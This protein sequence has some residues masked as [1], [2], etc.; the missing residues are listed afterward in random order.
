MDVDQTEPLYRYPYP[1]PELADQHPF[2]AHEHQ[3]LEDGEMSR[4]AKAFLA[5][6]AKRR[7]V[8]MFS[9]DPVPRDLIEVAVAAASTAP[10]GAHKQP[11]TFV[12]ISDPRT[13]ARICEAA[14]AEE[15]TNYLQNRMNAEWQ[16]SLA[17]LGTDHHKE[18]LEV[19]PWLVVLFEQR[20]ELRTDGSTRKNYYVKE[21]VGIAAG[22]FL[23]AIHDMGLAALPHTPSP[24]AFLRTLLGRPENERPFAMFPVGHPLPGVRVPDLQ[25]KAL[26]EVLIVLERSD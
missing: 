13:K 4:R 25:R 23:T 19:A 9:S 21:S 7:S 18:F 24:M 22:L 14:E 12:A 8:R 3:R 1:S 2:V 10:S 5:L 11:W 17:P 15:H 6:V 16:E 26:E 20:Y